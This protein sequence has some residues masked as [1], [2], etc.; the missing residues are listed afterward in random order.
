MFS[1]KVYWNAISADRGFESTTKI[2][3]LLG[4]FKDCQK[5]VLEVKLKLH[6]I[7]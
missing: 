6:S 4:T 5:I 3:G 7:N 1:T 2:Q